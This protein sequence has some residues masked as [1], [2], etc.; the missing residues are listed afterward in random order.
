MSSFHCCVVENRKKHIVN[1]T[2]TI[3]ITGPVDQA[4]L[5]HFCLHAKGDFLAMKELGETIPCK[6]KEQYDRDFEETDI[7]LVGVS[8]RIVPEG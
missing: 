3:E 8:A 7:D 1:V 4:L 6:S 5:D 2:T